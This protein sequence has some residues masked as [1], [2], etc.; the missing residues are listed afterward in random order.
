[1]LR[2][3]LRNVKRGYRPGLLIGYFDGSELPFVAEDVLLERPEQPLGV[4][5]RQ[6]DAALHLRLRHTGQHPCEIDHEIAAAVRDDGEVS[7]LSLCH[8]VWQFYLQSLLLVVLF[9]V[10]IFLLIITDGLTLL[11]PPMTLDIEVSEEL[12]AFQ[13]EDFGVHFATLLILES[14]NYYFL[15]PSSNRLFRKV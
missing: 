11:E 5:R 15:Y 14:V 1:M 8:V 4:F 3:S 9:L 13:K 7:I 6:D 2:F 10:H 12:H